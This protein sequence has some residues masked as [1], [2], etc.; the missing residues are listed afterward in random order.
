MR[1]LRPSYVN[2]AKL[3]VAKEFAKTIKFDIRVRKLDDMIKKMIYEINQIKE[4][5]NES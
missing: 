2:V 3:I 5:Q 4:I 1:K